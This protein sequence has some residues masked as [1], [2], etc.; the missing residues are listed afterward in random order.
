M[1]TTEEFDAWCQRL[2]FKPETV[3]IITRIRESL[4]VRKV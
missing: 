2:Q 3:E 1:L 4:P